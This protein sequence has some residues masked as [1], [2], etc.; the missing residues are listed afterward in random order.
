MAAECVAVVVGISLQ[1]LGVSGFEG[2]PL[3][4]DF[5]SRHLDTRCLQLS[6]SVATVFIGMN[7]RPSEVDSGMNPK[8]R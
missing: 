7:I 8:R 3:M 2:Q 1:G 6:N 5:S 4:F